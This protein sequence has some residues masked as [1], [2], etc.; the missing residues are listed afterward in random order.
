MAILV[1]DN[2]LKWD[3]KVKAYIQEF[4]MYHPYVTENFNIQD[5]LTHRTGFG[6]GSGD[7]IPIPSGA[8]FTI[9]DLLSSFQ[10]FKPVLAFRTKY[11]CDNIL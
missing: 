1:E 6:K 2:K 5:L 7:L 4:K 10:H 9:D 8:D 11:D 3:D